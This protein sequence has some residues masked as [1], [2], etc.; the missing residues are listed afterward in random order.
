MDVQMQTLYVDIA[1]V[2]EIFADFVRQVSV[3]DSVMRIELCVTRVDEPHEKEPQTGKVYTV[4]R[5][6]LPIPAALALQEHIALNVAELEKQG[7]VKRTTAPS[8]MTPKH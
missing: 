1:G 7:L 6:A 3:K 4:A 8:P 5:I 2:Q